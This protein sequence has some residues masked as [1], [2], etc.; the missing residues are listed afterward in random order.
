MVPYRRLSRPNTGV[1]FSHGG[2]PRPG[3]GVDRPRLPSVDDHREVGSRSASELHESRHF[4][5]DPGIPPPIPLPGGLRPLPGSHSS[6]ETRQPATG[7]MVRWLDGH[8][9]PSRGDQTLPYRR[10]NSIFRQRRGASKSDEFV[11]RIV[12]RRSY[13]RSPRRKLLVLLA[14]GMGGAGFEPATSTV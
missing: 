13:P 12:P 10:P 2:R 7:R 9:K 11:P 14:L 5:G 3:R 6:T 4:A 8:E 1:P